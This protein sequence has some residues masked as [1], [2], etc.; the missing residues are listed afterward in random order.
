MPRVI[1]GISV[2]RKGRANGNIVMA[3]QTDSVGA[4]PTQIELKRKM[5]LTQKRFM[6]R[7]NCSD[8]DLPTT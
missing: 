1:E 4:T 5:A 8:D 2:E 7:D 6:Q 3:T